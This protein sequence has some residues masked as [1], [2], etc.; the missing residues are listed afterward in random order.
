MNA[1]ISPLSGHSV[2]PTPRTQPRRIAI[3]GGGCTGLRLALLFKKWNECATQDNQVEVVVFEARPHA[4]GFLQSNKGSSGVLV[5]SGAQGVLASRTVFLQALEEA[6]MTPADVIAAPRSGPR[7][8]RYLISPTGQLARLS[9]F[10]LLRSGLSAPGDLLR[11]ALEIFKARPVRPPHPDESL[12]QFFSRHFGRIWAENF[13]LP[14]ATGIWGGGAEK[15]LLRHTFPQLQEIEIRR[16]SL[17]RTALLSILSRFVGGRKKALPGTHDWPKGLLSF[18]GGMHTLIEKMRATLENSGPWQSLRL[19]AP[20]HSLQQTAE[21]KYL[22][23]GNETFDFVFWTSGP[24]NSPELEFGHSDMKREWELLQNTPTHTFIVVNVSGK[25]SHLTRDGFGVLA[26]RESTGLLGVLFVH[27]IYQQHVPEDTFS[28][29]VL[30]G[31]D[32]N[33]AMISWSDEQLTEYTLIELKKLNLIDLPQEQ[34]TI[35]VIRWNRAI[36]IADLGHDG[37]MATLWRLQAHMPGLRFAGI[38]KKGV[39]VAD[40]LLSAQETFDDW[41]SALRPNP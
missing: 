12:Y 31:G 10:L 38:Y 18:P 24:W 17:I 5:E 1:E 29:R 27:S 6:G 25:R 41:V 20:V 4:G 3:V 22:I 28:Y 21:K 16:G 34:C 32:R 7:A 23:N 33:P 9:P 40:A 39:G 35:E 15:L 2:A 11:L 26:R 37:R 30:L 36:A 13:V 14:F 8:A 19:N